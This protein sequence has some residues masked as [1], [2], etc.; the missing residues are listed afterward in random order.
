MANHLET[1]PNRPKSTSSLVARCERLTLAALALIACVHIASAAYLGINGHSPYRQA[2]VYGHTLGFTGAKDFAAFDRFAT[3]GPVRIF[4]MPVYQYLIAKTALLTAGDP[5]VIARYFNLGFWLLAAFAGYRLCR[6]LGGRVGGRMGDRVAGLAFVYLL[7]TSPLVL[8]YYSAPIPDTLAVA[9]ALTGIALLASAGG[10]GWRGAARALPF[11]AVATLI[12]SPVVIPFIVFYAV[13]AAVMADRAGLGPRAS[14]RRSAPFIALALILLALALLAEQL[15]IVL[16]DAERRGFWAQGPNSPA[17]YFGSWALRTSAEFWNTLW[18]AVHLW[19]PFQFGYVYVVVAIAALS[20]RADRR[21]AAIIAAAMAAFFSGW[22]VF[23]GRYSMNDYYQLPVAALCFLSFAFA[24]SRMLS[25][26]LSFAMD[27]LPARV[28][29]PVAAQGKA[30]AL[31]LIATIPLA[32]TQVALQDSLSRRARAGLWPAIEHALRDEAVFLYVDLAAKISNSIPGGLVST[33]FAHASPRDFEENCADYLVR[34]AAVLSAVDSECLS[35]RRAQAD[36]FIEDN[37]LIFYL[38]R[39]TRVAP[40][41]AANPP[42]PIETDL[43][44]GAE[45]ESRLW[46]VSGPGRF[47]YRLERIDKEPTLSVRALEDMPWLAVFVHARNLR[48]GRYHKIAVAVTGPD[49]L[50]LHLEYWNF[51]GRAA[52]AH[53]TRPIHLSDGRMGRQSLALQFGAERTRDYVAVTAL[54]IKAGQTFRIHQLQ[55]RSSAWARFDSREKRR[56]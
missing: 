38:N 9:L 7:A 47:E 31:A 34:Y 3:H 11:L 23:P 56:N 50:R 21:L 10:G 55:L 27:K 29:A 54:G 4:D 12:K 45:S 48:D 42:R 13:Y 8:H 5:L 22:L 39:G 36:Y 19:G 30:A 37:D 43:L 49:T 17:R 44:Q 18:R 2:T 14:L 40:P 41:A 1:P 6:A 25:F 28:R 33:K 35:G 26:A 51:E 24:L 16:L 15:R 20:V 32:L 46:T 52:P 53:V